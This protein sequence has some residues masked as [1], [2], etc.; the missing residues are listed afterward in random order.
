MTE[1]EIENGLGGV[2]SKNGPRPQSVL[3]TLWSVLPGWLHHFVT[4]G[5]FVIFQPG[6]IRSARSEMVMGENFGERRKTGAAACSSIHFSNHKRSLLASVHNFIWKE[7][8]LYRYYMKHT[9]VSLNLKWPRL[10]LFDVFPAFFYPP[11][12]SVTLEDSLSWVFGLLLLSWA[13]N[14][15]CEDIKLISPFCHIAP[16]GAPLG[17]KIDLLCQISCF[18]QLKVVEWIRLLGAVKV[19]ETSSD[20]I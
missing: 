4:G 8:I 6:R 3:G 11:T 20:V 13:I 12:S 16:N 19:W 7:N 2:E 14:H 15:W 18:N 17:V 1:T 10:W 9:K 5:Q